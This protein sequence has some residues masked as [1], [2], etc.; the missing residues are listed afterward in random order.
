MRLCI[1][2]SF[3]IQVQCQYIHKLK[4]PHIALYVC[5][6]FSIFQIAWVLSRRPYWKSLKLISRFVQLEFGAITGGL[7]AQPD[8]IAPDMALCGEKVFLQWQRWQCPSITYG[9]LDSKKTLI[10]TLA[11]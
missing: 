10:H 7:F 1:S 8:E 6:I 11:H 9:L 3:V 2:V 4:A 5:Y